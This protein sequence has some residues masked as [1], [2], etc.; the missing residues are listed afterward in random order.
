MLWAQGR[1]IS[2][3]GGAR[4]E[5]FTAVGADS[6]YSVDGAKGERS[7]AHWSLWTQPATVLII[8][9]VMCAAHRYLR[10]MEALAILSSRSDLRL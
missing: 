6:T 9:G 10:A 7:N 3:L 1:D 8:L 2:W 5:R 4:G